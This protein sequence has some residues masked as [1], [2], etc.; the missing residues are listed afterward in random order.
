MYAPDGRDEPSLGLRLEA[1]FKEEVPAAEAP[2]ILVEGSVSKPRLTILSAHSFRKSSAGLVRWSD[3]EDQISLLK[4]V[5][6]MLEE[7]DG[8]E[9]RDEVYVEKGGD[10]AQA[11]HDF[12]SASTLVIVWVTPELWHVP[13]CMEMVD[14]VAALV[15][16]RQIRATCVLAKTCDWH[17][18]QSPS[19]FQLFQYPWQ[20]LNHIALDAQ[21]NP[22]DQYPHIKAMAEQWLDILFPKAQ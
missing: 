15:R 21:S 18:A 10:V 22:A 4:T 20:P 17:D 16:A 11:M 5:V 1:A 3:L 8:V 12:I 6:M 14:H 2:A 19:L 9:K 13:E 7:F